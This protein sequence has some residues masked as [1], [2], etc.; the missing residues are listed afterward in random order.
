MPAPATIAVQLACTSSTL[1]N[2]TRRRVL[3]GAGALVAEPGV[4][5]RVGEHDDAVRIG[6]ARHL[7][8]A[9]VVEVLPRRVQPPVVACKQ[10]GGPAG[11]HLAAGLQRHVH[12]V[13]RRGIRRAT[14]AQRHVHF[15]IAP[16]EARDDRHQHRTDEAGRRAHSQQ[17]DRLHRQPRHHHLR[18]RQFP[19]RARCRARQHARARVSSTACEL[20]ASSSVASLASSCRMREET[21]ERDTP[22]IVSIGEPMIE[23]NQTRQNRRESRTT[24]R[25][26]AV[27]P[28]T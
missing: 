8:R 19:Q 23:F 17:T 2:R 9:A 18:L 24:C 4:Q 13:V 16:R 6:F 1:T 22:D 12:V 27:T 20:R 25:G 5:E 26:S 11:G 10:P 15:G 7:R 21:V 28:R 14:D 3:P